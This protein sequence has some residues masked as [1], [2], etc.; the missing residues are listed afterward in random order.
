MAQQVTSPTCT[1]DNA[2]SIPGLTQWFKVPH[3]CGCGVGW[4]PQLLAWDLPYALGVALKKNNN[5]QKRKKKKK[6]ECHQ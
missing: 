4:Q 5:K 1:H 3:Y 2:A 6:K